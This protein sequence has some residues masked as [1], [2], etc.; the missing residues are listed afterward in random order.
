MHGIIGK[1]MAA[2][3]C[4][5][6][7]AQRLIEGSLDQPGC[8]SYI[9]AQ[10]SLDEDA[11]WITEIWESREAHAD[12]LGSWA[13]QKTLADARDLIAGFAHRLETTPVGGK[14]LPPTTGEQIGNRA[15]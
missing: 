9:V 10:D 5:E 2:S 14:G 1:V 13:M 6:A 7:L 3:G 11:L 15:P 8:L 12:A 4:R